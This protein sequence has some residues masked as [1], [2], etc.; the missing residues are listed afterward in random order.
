MDPLCDVI[1]L[2]R[3]HAVFSKS[4]T[5]KGRWGIRYSAYALPSFSIVLKGRC[6]IALEG[7]PPVLLQQGDFLL[8]PVSPAFRMYSEAGVPCV[9]QQPTKHTVHHGETVGEP[10][11]HM[12]GGTFEI[13]PANAPLLLQLLPEMVHIRATDGDTSR[14]ARITALIVEE[15]TSS[16]P[17]RNMILERLLEVMLIEALRWRSLGKDAMHPGLLAGLRDP[18][19]ASALRAIHSDVRRGWTVAELARH[20]G[21]SRSAFAASFAEIVGCAPMEYL[22][23]WR[24]SLAQDALSN[25]RASL[26]HVAHEI[27]YQSTSAFSTA[28]RRRTGYAPGAFARARRAANHANG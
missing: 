5:G 21:M 23:R 2:L 1:A 15:G 13:E 11:L 28:F 20:V 14:F 25:E 10:D 9:P 26:D 8:L 7:A 4:V 12:L 24:I 19:L 17:G 27:G 6:W 18:A 22:S 16:R 3:P